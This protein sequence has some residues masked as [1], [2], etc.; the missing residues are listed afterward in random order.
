MTTAVPP[1]G[2]LDVAIASVLLLIAA[3]FLA[4]AAAAIKLDQPRAP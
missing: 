3:P 4:L 1:S 2:A